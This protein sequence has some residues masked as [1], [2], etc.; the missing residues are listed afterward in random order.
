MSAHI[1]LLGP[2]AGQPR[3]PTD[4]VLDR[5]HLAKQVT[6]ALK[7]NNFEVIGW[8][9]ASDKR[10]VVEVKYSRRCDQEIALGKAVLY[11]D[12]PDEQRGQFMVDGARVMWLVP[13][14]V[15]LSFATPAKRDSRACRAVG[16]EPC[17]R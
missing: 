15:G 13:Q 4:E 14:R 1:V 9:I 2:R 6:L 12:G 16:A 8:R 3:S 17:A 10:V 7:R 5:A 11:R